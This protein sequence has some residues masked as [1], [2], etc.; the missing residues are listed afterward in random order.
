ML[1][2]RARRRAFGFP[3]GAFENRPQQASAAGDGA[4]TVRA[5]AAPLGA[6]AVGV[7]A[8]SGGLPD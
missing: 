4:V 3:G 2:G 7:A 1:E 8:G 5:G 6:D